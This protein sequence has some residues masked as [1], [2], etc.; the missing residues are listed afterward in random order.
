MDLLKQINDDLHET[1]NHMGERQFNSYH[2]WKRAVK[3]RDPNAHIEG[4][5]D[6]ANAKGHGEWDGEKGVIYHD[7][8]KKESVESTE[9]PI[10]ELSKKS[11]ASYI[12]SAAKDVDTQSM[13]VHSGGYGNGDED[14]LKRRHKGIEKAVDKL[15]KDDKSAKESEE[16]KS[17]PLTELSHAKLS[18]YQKAASKDH[19]KQSKDGNKDKAKKRVKGLVKAQLKKKTLEETQ[20]TETQRGSPQTIQFLSSLKANPMVDKIIRIHGT[21]TGSTALIRLKDGNAIEVIVNAPQFGQYH[22]DARK[23]DQYKARRMKKR[24]ASGVGV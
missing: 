15:A 20:L 17:E 13:M 23:D 24:A 2:G 5:K 9:E 1:K 4:D 18:S 6:I 7:H 22:Q 12:K 8:P 3:K 10:N 19:V 21:G 16:T 11:L 14:K